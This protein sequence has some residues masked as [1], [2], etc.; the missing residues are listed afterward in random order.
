MR[1]IKVTK[2]KRVEKGRYVRT[3][4]AFMQTVTSAEGRKW[5]CGVSCIGWF[6][7][8]TGFKTARAAREAANTILLEY[9]NE[10]S[11][12]VIA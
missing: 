2:W 7:H 1:E 10:L 3:L 5:D 4:D 8:I 6:T 11:L 12:R 9:L